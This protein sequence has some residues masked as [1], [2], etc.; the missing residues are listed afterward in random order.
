MF[1]TAKS[2]TGD[3]SSW[4]VSNVDGKPRDFNLNGNNFKEPKWES[5]NVFGFGNYLFIKAVIGLVLLLVYWRRSKN[6]SS[7]TT[8]I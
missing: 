3:L 1:R 6:Q 7:E 2:F 8:L 4:D 5:S